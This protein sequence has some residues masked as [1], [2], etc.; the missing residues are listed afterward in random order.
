MNLALLSRVILRMFSKLKTNAKNGS[1][2]GSEGVYF[3]RAVIRTICVQRR[4]MASACD[5]CRGGRLWMQSRNG[6]S[7]VRVRPL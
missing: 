5:S 1:K 3:D 2:R 7:S 4:G 6:A